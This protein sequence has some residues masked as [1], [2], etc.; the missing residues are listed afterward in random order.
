MMMVMV[1]LA[2]AARCLPEQQQQRTL[3]SFVYTLA[4]SRPSGAFYGAQTP[5]RSSNWGSFAG[6]LRFWLLVVV[7]FI[8]IVTFGFA[9]GI[10]PRSG[11]GDLLAPT[12]Q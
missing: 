5:S 4:L 1:F 10:D 6:F 12:S 9:Y 2:A 3:C 7:V 11:V 8:G